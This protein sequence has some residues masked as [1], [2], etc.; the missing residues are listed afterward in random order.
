MGKM[1][2]LAVD[3]NVVNLATIE[4]ELRDQYEVIPVISGNR[5]I[6][7]MYQEKVD[8]IL[9]DIEMPL[10]DGI[11]TLKKIRTQ[12]NGVTVPVIM[13][14]AKHDKATVIEGTKLGIM[15]YILKPFDGDDLRQRIERALMRRGA[16]PMNEAETYQRIEEIAKCIQNKNPN[17]AYTKLDEML[18]YHLDDEINKRLQAARK[19]LKNEE[20]D[21]AERMLL[22]V[23]QF[24]NQETMKQEEP[25]LLPISLG[26]LNAKLLFILDDL[27]H[28]HVE[29]AEEKLDDLMRYSIPNVI[30]DKCHNAHACIKEYDDGGA[31]EL[32]RQ[33]LKD[34]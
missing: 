2:I 18:N 28:F 27:E 34:L 31:E 4:Q 21:T 17:L 11:E 24:I 23:L 8:L 19:K 22:R 15:D 12:E 14:T 13:L 1:R 7:F 3:D 16:L 33:A 25:E 29:D 6:K 32:I 9:L 10:M 5:A 30:K 26:E 20:Y